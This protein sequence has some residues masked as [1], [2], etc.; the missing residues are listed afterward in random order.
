MVN[1]YFIFCMF[2]VLY[3]VFL[4]LR[5]L[6]KIVRKYIYGTKLFLS[7]QKERQVS[8]P[9]S[10]SSLRLGVN[11]TYKDFLHKHPLTE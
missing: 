6:K 5:K 1:T 4:Q 7:K 3:I 9:I 2:Y 10:S 8:G 11:C